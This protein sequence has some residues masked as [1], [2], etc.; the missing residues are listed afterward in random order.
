[1]EAAVDTET[2]QRLRRVF[3]HLARVLRPTEA[4]L[5]ADLTPTRVAVLLN[6]VRNGPTRLADVAEQEGLNPTLLSR[7]IAKLAEDGLVV[8][9]AD[10]SDR[11]SAWLDATPAGHELATEI[12]AQRTQALEAALVQLSSADRKLVEASLPALERLAQ[13]LHEGGK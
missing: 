3:G 6:T 11:R 13:L 2:A 7:T 4:G 10:E 5:A 12:R 9:K 1:M 8:R